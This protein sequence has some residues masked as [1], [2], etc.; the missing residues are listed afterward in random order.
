[1]A[2]EELTFPRLMYRGAPDTL[3]LGTHAHPKTGDLIGETKQVDSQ[4]D[5]DDAKKDGW[6]LT[7]DTPKSAA[8]QRADAADATAEAK[9]DARA[10]KGLPAPAHNALKK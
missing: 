4:K 10:D 3:G 7:R 6:R 1:M 8:E 9:A 2:H 5:C